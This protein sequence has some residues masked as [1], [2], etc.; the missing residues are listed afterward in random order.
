M[1]TLSKLYTW[2]AFPPNPPAAECMAEFNQILNLVNGGTSNRRGYSVFSD[3]TLPVWR[4]DQLSAGDIA[5]FQVNG[6]SKAY[7]NATGQ[8][9]NSLA[10]GTAPFSIAS[11]TKCTNLNADLVDG[12]NASQL[13]RSDVVGEDV[14]GD[15]QITKASLGTQSLIIAVDNDITTF[16]RSSD[17]GTIFTITTM[18]GSTRVMVWPSTLNTQVNF[19]PAGSTDL[20]TLAQL[21]ATPQA[22]APSSTMSTIG[23]G[24]MQAVNDRASAWICP[25][26]SSYTVVSLKASCITT[27]GSGTSVVTFYVNNASIGTVSLLS[28]DSLY[29]VKTN[30][31]AD[32][33]LSEGDRLECRLTTDSGINGAVGG[34]MMTRT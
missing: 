1:T 17:G 24:Y 31:I 26:S 5:Q 13:L 22:F 30:N 29:Q 18:N 6:S 19:T 27:I 32:A 2:V 10:T 25:A 7:I 16:K 21:P 8:L 14:L 34:F 20:V 33:A 3:A 9:V 4:L 15:F 12:L 23:T 11:T 28:T